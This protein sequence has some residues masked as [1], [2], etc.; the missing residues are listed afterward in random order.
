MRANR[1]L[2]FFSIN[3][4]ARRANL[5]CTNYNTSSY[6]LSVKTMNRFEKWNVDA[7]FFSNAV[8]DFDTGEDATVADTNRRETAETGHFRGYCWRWQKLR[9]FWISKEF[10]CINIKFG[11][12]VF[13]VVVPWRDSKN[14]KVRK[15][16]KIVPTFRRRA[17]GGRCTFSRKS[18][19]SLHFQTRCGGGGGPYGFTRTLR[20][21]GSALPCWPNST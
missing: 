18:L 15:T 2:M 11:Q 21:L 5:K 10:C 12:F 7:S 4:Q 16:F 13:F 6:N 17:G 19:W 8:A 1:N 9:W 14:N 20:P 3:R